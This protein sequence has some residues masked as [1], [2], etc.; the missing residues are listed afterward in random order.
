[1]D[2]QNMIG[3]GCLTVETD[4]EFLPTSGK[5][6]SSPSSYAVLVAFHA[7]L[8]ITPKESE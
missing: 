7:P 2:D 3:L 8:A 4:R 6:R 1:M 5:R